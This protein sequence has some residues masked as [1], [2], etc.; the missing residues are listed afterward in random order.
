MTSRK[1]PHRW[2]STD[3]AL[4]ARHR[5]RQETTPRRTAPGADDFLDDVRDEVFDAPDMPAATHE[6]LVA[7][8]RFVTPVF[9]ACLA[10]A[11]ALIAWPLLRA[12]LEMAQ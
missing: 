2:N 3:I 4:A 11:V 1:P 10:G 9:A 12:A 8:L 6:R 5:A 7:V